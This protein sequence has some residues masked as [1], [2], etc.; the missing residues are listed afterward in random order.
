MSSLEG[1]QREK[2]RGPRSEPWSI[3]TLRDQSEEKESAREAEKA[4]SVK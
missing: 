4:Q 1:V 3:P 2:N